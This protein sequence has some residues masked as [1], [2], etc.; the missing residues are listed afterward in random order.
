MPIFE[1]LVIV[2]AVLSAVK[3]KNMGIKRINNSDF[4]AG[5]CGGIAKHF[6][7]PIVAVRILALASCALAG[8]GA[9]FYIIF[10]LILPAEGSEAK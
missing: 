7:W 4:M 10:A 3:A 8:A 2:I 6:D 1:F 9:A 5:V